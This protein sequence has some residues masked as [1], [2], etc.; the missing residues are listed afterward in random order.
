[1]Y[2][3]LYK[4]NYYNLPRSARSFLGSLYGTNPLKIRFGRQY[5][6]HNRI[7]EEF[8]NSDE[9]FRFDYMFNKTFETMHFTYENI[10]Y[11]TKK[12]DEYHFKPNDFKSLTI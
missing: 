5:R 10:P 9:Q 7:V 8:E 11:Y 6:I 4:K 3:H 1:M 12:L 2:S